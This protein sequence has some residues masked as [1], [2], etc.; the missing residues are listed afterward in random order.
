[1]PPR[2][3][4]EILDRLPPQ[5]IEAEKGVLGSLL[6]DPMLCDDIAL[7]LRGEDFY[8]DAHQRIYR[9]IMA[10]HDDGKRVDVTLL[11]ARLKKEQEYEAIGGAAC[12]ADIAQAVPYAHNARHYAEIV[13]DKATAR[14]LIHATTEIMRE[15]WDPGIAPGELVSS[16]E[17]RIFAV[18][19]RRSADQI[20][21]VQDLLIEAFDRIDDRAAKGAG[22]AAPSGFADLDAMTGGLHPSE[23]IV[24][25]ARPSMGKTALAT[26]IAENVAIESKVPTLF[27]SLEMSRL[28]LANRLLCSQGSIDGSKFRS[29]FISAE[30]REKLMEAAGRLSQSP[31]FIDDTPSRTVSEIAACARRLKRKENLGLV[32]VD[33][34]QLIQPDEPRDP[35]QEQVAKMARRLKGLAR[36]LKIPV[37]VLAQLNRQAEQG[38]R[39]ESHRPKL[40]HLRE[41]GAIE[42]DADVVMFIHREEYYHTKEKADELG[43][44]GQASLIVAK[45]RSGPTGDVKLSW[46]SQFTRFNNF[47]GK[48]YAEFTGY[49]NEF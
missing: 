10:L 3:S 1:M 37:L 48:P 46:N 17:E 12:L 28:E 39:D 31:L 8:A 7:L 19:D 16:A 14:E 13:R 30:D 4:S 2:V 38:T 11:V 34:L 32:V 9:H 29:G 21:H 44:T 45:Q 26:N 24:L 36:E 23:F 25:A 43:V 27:V 22:D 40:S 49:A 47:S 33:Y 35:R 5:S 6:L 15:A 20:T 41:S 42:Q 18:H